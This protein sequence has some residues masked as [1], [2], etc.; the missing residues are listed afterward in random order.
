MTGVMTRIQAVDPLDPDGRQLFEQ[1]VG[2]HAAADDALWRGQGGSWSADEVR[3]LQR[4]TA[5]RRTSFAAVEDSG[6][7]VGAVQVLEPLR[8]NLDRVHVW[9]SVRPD[10]WRQGIGSALLRTAENLAGAAE[11][12]VINNRSSS[13]QE[14]GGAGAAFAR[15]HG[16]ALAQEE[17]R[18]EL[19]LPLDPTTTDCATTDRATTDPEATDPDWRPDN[20]GEHPE[21]VI[22]TVWDTL[23]E[24]W[25]EDRA[26]L[27]R[28]ISTDA[29]MGGLD[30]EE[31]SWDA[32][33]VR[34]QWA[35]GR[36]QGRR[37]VESV[38]RH[39]TSG[40]LVG[41]TDLLISAATPNL[42]YQADTL[43]L[44]EHRGHG[45]GAALKRAS[46]VAV[47]RHQPQV[48]TVRTWNARSNEPMLRVNRE[49]GF[50]TTGY[51]Q[52]WQKRLG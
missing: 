31:E 13:P 41:F 25:L 40:R 32:D 10:R 44:R 37:A 39:L 6:A 9:L 38:A 36:A 33:R 20:C 47:Q 17:L 24:E 42:G 26:V 50:V 15:H 19:T 49:L 30:L 48:R 18:Q 11:R 28:R 34:E 27:A 7:V 21:Y 16:Y 14:S 8:D 46:L 5:G 45:L 43:V 2:V 35:R 22:E 51:T 29:P 23:P 3:E 4:A 52:E 1:W 12:S